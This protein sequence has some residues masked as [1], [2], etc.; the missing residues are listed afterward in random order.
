MADNYRQCPPMV[1]DVE[2]TVAFYATHFDFEL[3]QPANA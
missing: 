3:L 1:D 2:P